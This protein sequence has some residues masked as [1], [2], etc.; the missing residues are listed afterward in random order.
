MALNYSLIPTE[1]LKALKT[2]DY[3]SVSTRTLQYIKTGDAAGMQAATSEPTAMYRSVGQRMGSKLGARAKDFGSEAGKLAHNAWT[4]G[5]DP[6]RGTFRPLLRMEG[7]IAN[8]ANDI[9]GETGKSFFNTIATPPQ[10]RHYRSDPLQ[11]EIRS[12]HFIIPKG[13]DEHDPLV[14]AGRWALKQGGKYYE[15]FK[16][17]HPEVAKDL[18]AAAGIAAWLPLFKGGKI[19]EEG[20]GSAVEHAGGALEGAEARG[21][22]EALGVAPE[23]AEEVPAVAE[24]AAERVPEASPKGAEPRV[25]SGAEVE[26]DIIMG[27]PVSAA[28][29]RLHPGL[30]EKHERDFVRTAE[31]NINFGVLD[32][33]VLGGRL[34]GPIRLQRGAKRTIENPGFGEFHVNSDHGKDIGRVGFSN[35]RDFVEDTVRGATEVWG[36]PNGKLMLVK[37]NGKDHLA[38]VEFQKEGLF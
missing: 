4:G 32:M 8:A 2:R 26:R 9:I 3:R 36:Q 12:D 30:L 23:G 27:K 17:T 14:K 21:A 35:A 1:D 19:V 33:R 31:G 5:V 16:K 6:Y 10:N 25:P 37:K 15:L 13:P 11:T 20:I 18:E 24:K 38:I 28:H 7:D 29:M 22:E 34:G